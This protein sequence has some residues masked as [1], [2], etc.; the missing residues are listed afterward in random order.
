MSSKPDP[1]AFIEPDEHDHAA[2]VALSKG[3]ATEHQQVLALR[4]IVNNFSRAHDLLYIPDSFDQSA[5]LN[6]RAFVGQKI[7]KFINKPVGKIS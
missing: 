5:F 3:E 2:L 4:L 7:L 1:C 6:G